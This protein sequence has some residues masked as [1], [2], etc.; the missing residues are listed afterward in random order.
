MHF[1]V[2]C[3]GSQWTAKSHGVGSDVSRAYALDSDAK[4]WYKRVLGNE[5]ASFG[6]KFYTEDVAAALAAL[7]ADRAE[8][9]YQLHLS[10]EL[11][12]TGP[13]MAQQLAAPVA[14]RVLE[15]L[16]EKPASHPGYKRL[17]NVLGLFPRPAA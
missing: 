4:S 7:W 12:E 16:R 10:G 1:E 13:T 9:W 14:D 6:L 8:Y 5:M 17:V 11:A 3:V 15:T 2:A